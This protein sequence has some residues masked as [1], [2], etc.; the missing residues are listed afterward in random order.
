MEINKIYQGN[1]NKELRTDPNNLVLLCEVCHNFVH[2][3][4]NKNREFLGGGDVC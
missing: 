4:L 2:S 3:K 1:E